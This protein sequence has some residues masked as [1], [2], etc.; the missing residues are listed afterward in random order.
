MITILSNTTSPHN[1]HMN[2]MV[3]KTFEKYQQSAHHYLVYDNEGYSWLF[4]AT[5]CW[6][7]Q[8]PRQDFVQIERR[9]LQALKANLKRDLY[10]MNYGIAALTHVAKM[11]KGEEKELNYRAVTL[12]KKK[13]S[14]AEKQMKAIKKALT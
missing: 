2:V 3:G 10:Q 14:V 5:D 7:T 4:K 1:K 12:L 8:K 6:V 11:S 9:L 13:R